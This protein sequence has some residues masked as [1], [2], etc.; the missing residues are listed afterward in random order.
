MEYITGRT[1]FPNNSF[2]DDGCSVAEIKYKNRQIAEADAKFYAAL[3]EMMTMYD[4]WDVQALGFVIVEDIDG[5]AE[6]NLIALLDRRIEE[7][8][9]LD[10]ENAIQDLPVDDIVKIYLKEIAQY[11]TLTV[12]EELELTTRYAETG[13]QQAKQKIT[14]H[15][16][17]LVVSV[18]KRYIFANVDFLDLIQEGNIGLMKAIDKFDPRKGFKLSTYATWWIRQG[19]TRTIS[20]TSRTIRLP[21]HVHGLQN[22]IKK[23][24]TKFFN[25]NNRDATP[26]EI[27]I[28]L[29]VTAAAVENSIRLAQHTLSLDYDNR[30]SDEKGSLSNTLISTSEHSP[31]V[32]FENASLG[33][34]LAKA[35]SHLEL[36]EQTII[37]RNFGLDGKPPES[38]GT[39]GKD[40]GISKERVRQIRDAAFIKLRN[41]DA[42]L[43]QLQDYLT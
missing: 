25:E 1:E 16:L 34:D 36:R 26:E 7:Y 23:A 15:N 2:A 32:I 33:C 5:E 30:D 9:Q 4:E 17:R 11:K 3:E 20:N 13:D 12:A 19:I 14:N 37:V 22:K 27:A 43:Q 40:L 31:E 8:L 10:W 39:I 6:H 21:G 29:D 18:A 38:Y 28:L 41:N 24:Q 42:V 35:L